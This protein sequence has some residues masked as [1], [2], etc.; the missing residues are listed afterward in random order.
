MPEPGGGGEEREFFCGEAAS[1]HEAD[2][3]DGDARID[4]AVAMD[5]LVHAFA[6]R[7]V[8]PSALSQQESSSCPVRAL[9]AIRHAGLRSAI[10]NALGASG[11]VIV[12][13]QV[14]NR[15]N[16][17]QTARA[18]P[19]D[20]VVLGKGLLGNGA[21]I[22]LRELVDALGG[23][24]VV[25]VGLDDNDAYAPLVAAAGAAGYLLLDGDP[26]PLVDALLLA[27]G[28]APAALCC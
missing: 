19:A 22:A 9:V 27:T 28:R 15:A 5:A 1:R 24:P 16:L 3:D 4:H 21:A 2:P 11:V 8:T 14:G 20:V 26:N 25:V 23:I 10:C 18:I 17:W 12:V 6:G 7:V 13:A